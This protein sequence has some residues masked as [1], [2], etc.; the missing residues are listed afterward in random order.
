V[1]LIDIVAV[2][3]PQS[4]SPVNVVVVHCALGLTRFAVAFSA[5]ICTLA[6]PSAVSIAEFYP[7]DGAVSSPHGL[8][9]DAYRPRRI[10][11]E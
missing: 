11:I 10:G 2:D 6:R 7:P 1:S 3:S 5:G 9:A 8:Q 4:V